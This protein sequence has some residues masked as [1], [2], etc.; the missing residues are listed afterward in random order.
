VRDDASD[1]TRRAE[2]S[3]KGVSNDFAVLWF[4]VLLLGLDLDWRGLMSGHFFIVILDI[5]LI[6]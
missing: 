5:K 1:I 6:N 4:W 3:S 2:E